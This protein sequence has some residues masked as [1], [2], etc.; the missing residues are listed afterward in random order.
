MGAVLDEIAGRLQGLKPSIDIN[1][2]M[3]P[4]TLTEAPTALD[5]ISFQ[6]NTGIQQKGYTELRNDLEAAQ[7]A[8]GRRAFAG[9]THLDADHWALQASL[10]VTDGYGLREIWRLPPT[11]E[12]QLSGA[13]SGG[14][15]A[16]SQAFGATSFAAH[17]GSI[18][19]MPDITALHIG[20]TDSVCKIHIDTAGFLFE[21]GGALMLTPD[22]FGHSA[23][24]LGLKTLVRDALPSVMAPLIARISLVYPHLGNS[25]TRTGPSSGHLLNM[26][27]KIPLFGR[28]LQGVKLPGVLGKIPLPG[29]EI[30]LLQGKR[31]TLKVVASCSVMGATECSIA[32]GVTGTYD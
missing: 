16:E 32:A 25:Y 27:K 31:V 5:G 12:L 1:Q 4:S 24:E 6:F 21:S 15:F 9:S 22:L 7:D 13:F 10:A 30:D 20:M 18:P 26:S 11:P 28:A 23:D 19:S 8:N 14:P 2:Y 29:L 3:A 17:F